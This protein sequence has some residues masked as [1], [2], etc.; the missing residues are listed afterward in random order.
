MI[1]STS[2][3]ATMAQDNP[4]PTRRR[5]VPLTEL[6]I[7]PPGNDR[8]APPPSPLKKSFTDSVKEREEKT[9]AELLTHFKNLM[10]LAARPIEEGATTELAAA[11]A[12]EM[13]NESSA[14]VSLQLEL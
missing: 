9:V 11:Q 5:V 12:V 1:P 13:E 8:V 7:L 3:I 14:L 6:L 2:A 10:D 4:S